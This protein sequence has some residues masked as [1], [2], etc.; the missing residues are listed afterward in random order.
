MLARSLTR[1]ADHQEEIG[2]EQK[3]NAGVDLFFTVH[4][5]RNTALALSAERLGAVYGQDFSKVVSKYAVAG[6][7]AECCARLREY[8]DAGARS[9]LVDSVCSDEYEEENWHWL[10]TEVLPA[11]RD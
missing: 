1:I 8:I 5:D 7:P 10:T 4:E 9:I 2:R 6:T 11:F 3:M